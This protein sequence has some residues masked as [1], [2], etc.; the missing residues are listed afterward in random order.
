MQDVSTAATTSFLHR[1]PSLCVAWPS[2]YKLQKEVIKAFSQILREDA[3]TG[4]C[5]R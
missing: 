2:P 4:Q 5:C 1:P 3:Q